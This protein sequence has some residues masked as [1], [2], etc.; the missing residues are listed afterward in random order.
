MPFPDRRFGRAGQDERP[1]NA[2]SKE[3]A[4]TPNE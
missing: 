3:R 1:G 4:T 2:P